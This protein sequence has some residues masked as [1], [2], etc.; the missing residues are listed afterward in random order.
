MYQV[1][2][3]K[4]RPQRLD[5][6]VGQPHV[7]R[8]LENA[9]AGGR[10]A[11]AY[12]FA[13]LRGTGKTS[14]ARIL[15]KCLNCVNGPT[16]TPCDA[17]VSCL[18]IIE[19]RSLD[20]MEL[21]AASRTGVD[22]IRELQEVVAYAPVRDRYKI[23]IID[24]AHMLSKA[25]FNA[26]LKTLEEPPPRVVFILATT[27]IQRLLPTILSRCQVFEFHRVP[28]K[29]ILAHLRHIA[30]AE[31]IA[32]S[33]GTLERVARAGEGSLRDALSVLERVLAFCGST[34]GDEDA[35]Q[36]LGAVRTEVLV[37]IVR[38]I[39]A[40]DAAALLA[41]LD[42]LVDDGHDLV[43]FWSEAV[44]VVRDL[45]L[46]RAWP[47]GGEALSR[48][49]EEVAALAQAGGTLSLEDWTRVFQI[50]ASLEYG[51]KASSQPR[52]LF[53]GALIRMASLGA[54][55]PIEEIL[56]S[57]GGPPPPAAAPTTKRGAAPAAQ[58]PAPPSPVAKGFE[59]TREAVVSA[60]TTARPMLGAILQRA[61]A[62]IVDGGTLVVTF[63]PAD[64]GVR[65]TLLGEDNVRSVEQ[66]VTQTLGRPVVLRVAET[67]D[68][69]V[70]A[71]NATAPTS[72]EE[73]KEH[74]AERARKDPAVSRVL[75][76]FGAQVVDVRPHRNEPEPPPSVEENG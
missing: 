43:H 23:L 6:L 14:V 75:T 4:W 64:S 52:F 8:T 38:G 34:V 56:A 11:H 49:P 73:S 39:A 70:T 57:L 55:R 45:M 53:E 48:T 44:G 59:D 35:L 40:R 29:S 22:N 62:V 10:L 26:L 9:I 72:S 37:E 3:R 1:L 60:V 21:D 65:R 58:P 16:V 24:E 30:D 71:V 13:G 19:G 25:A 66:I 2:A 12:V 68:T 69:A 51:L 41:A 36:V 32:V 63:G 50:L 17:C 15:A 61:A 27:E 46:L 54:V 67:S 7:A 28:V 33:D 42:A 20:V 18:E 47:A 76:E 5:Q 31:K 74:L